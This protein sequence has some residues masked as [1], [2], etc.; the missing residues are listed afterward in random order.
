MFFVYRHRSICW[1]PTQAYNNN[2][3]AKSIISPRANKKHTMYGTHTM[4]ET[5]N[6]CQES[7]QYQTKTKMHYHFPLYKNYVISS[8]NA[9]TLIGS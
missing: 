1:W 7:T 4:Y 5:H 2:K 9:I 8:R 6:V 3:Q